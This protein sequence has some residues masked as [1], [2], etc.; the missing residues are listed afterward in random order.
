MRKQ[1]LGDD[2]DLRKFCLLRFL[3]NSLKTD[4]FIN[5]MRTDPTGLSEKFD[6]EIMEIYQCLVDYKKSHMK[7][8]RC[9][10]SFA[11]E[12]L[13]SIL[14]Q[15]IEHDCYSKCVP[16]DNKGRKEWWGGF[17]QELRNKN[18][19]KLRNKKERKNNLVFLDPDTGIDPFDTSTSKKTIP[20]N[21]QNNHYPEVVHISI[22]EISELKQ[23]E[24]DYILIYQHTTMGS[25]KERKESLKNKM[26]ELCDHSE[27][28]HALCF[29]GGFNPQKESWLE[30]YILLLTDGDT[31]NGIKIAFTGKFCQSFLH[32]WEIE[33]PIP[34]RTN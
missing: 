22:D 18:L 15:N 5:W 21:S 3:C 24:A 28:K 19:Q 10:L 31:K 17:L 2:H 16:A 1:W 23:P 20:P 26:V 6:D 8:N 27:Y 9:L 11:K 12:C 33:C 13:P 14:G 29:L 4:V 25:I 34:S 7:D 32:I 30:A